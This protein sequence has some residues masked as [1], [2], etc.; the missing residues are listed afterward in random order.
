MKALLRGISQ[1]LFVAAGLLFFAGGLAINLVTK[2]D[3][4]SAEMM[5]IGSAFVL[6]IF[7]M[8]AKNASDNF[9]DN[10]SIGQ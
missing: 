10:D 8:V 5:G 9:D 1:T 2:M 7:G 6:G 4:L 3:R